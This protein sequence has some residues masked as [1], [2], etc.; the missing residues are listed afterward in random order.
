MRST[1]RC[2]AAMF[3]E[4]DPNLVQGSLQVDCVREH[5]VR[6]EVLPNEG[7]HVKKIWDGLKIHVI[8]SELIDFP[9]QFASHLLKDFFPRMCRE[10]LHFRIKSDT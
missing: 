8:R 6:R 10:C 2:R 1:A 4:R 9:A 7:A 3:S 5:Q